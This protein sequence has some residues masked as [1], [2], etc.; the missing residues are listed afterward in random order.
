M[1][2][3]AGAGRCAADAAQ[4]ARFALPLASYLGIAEP[5]LVE[6]PALGPEAP[7]LDL[8][9]AFRPVEDL[10]QKQGRD[11]VDGTDIQ[12]TQR[13]DVAVPG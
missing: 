2:G 4:E 11:A 9:A 10:R 7:R 13:A 12:A 8:E 6:R 1:R 5:S 3:Q